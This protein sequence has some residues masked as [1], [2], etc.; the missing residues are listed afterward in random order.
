MLQSIKRIF[1][2]CFSKSEIFL[3]A[4]V[5]LPVSVAVLSPTSANVLVASLGEDS[6][7]SALGVWI[8]KLH[9]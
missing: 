9:L 6:G 1:V 3:K 2:V 7:L 5:A 4:Y 8:L